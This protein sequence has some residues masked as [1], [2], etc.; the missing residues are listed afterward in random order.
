MKVILVSVDGMRPDALK[1]IAQVQDLIR[2]SSHTLSARTVFPPVT[3]PAHM[4]MFLGV[5]P[6]RHGTTTNTYTPQVRPINGLVEQLRANG[7][8][9]AF[10]YN[11]GQLRDL[12]PPGYLTFS[13]FF[14]A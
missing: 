5:D 1:N 12:V 9:C 14:S 11:W 13:F 3:L 4:S 10:F 7:N 8:T 6:D 2:R